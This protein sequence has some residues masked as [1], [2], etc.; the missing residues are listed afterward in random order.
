MAF[1]SCFQGTKQ[2]IDILVPVRVINAVKHYIMY[3]Q[4]L[5]TIEP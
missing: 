2:Q 3:N 1:L 5:C 4:Q